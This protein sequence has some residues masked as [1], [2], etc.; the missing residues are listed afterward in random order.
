MA[1]NPVEPT[2]A[3]PDVQPGAG[4]GRQVQVP[5]SNDTS[6]ED[7]Y[8]IDP[9]QEPVN[10][11]D[12]ADLP[13]ADRARGVKGMWDRQDMDPDA[14]AETGDDVEIHRNPA[15]ASRQAKP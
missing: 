2:E 13:V 6:D 9:S 3:E 7:P 15:G 8:A 4:G 1:R 14:E 5:S 12:N 11:A 10:V